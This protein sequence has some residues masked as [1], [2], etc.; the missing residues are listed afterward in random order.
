MSYRCQLRTCNFFSLVLA[1]SGSWFDYHRYCRIGVAFKPNEE[2][3]HSVDIIF[4]VLILNLTQ[5]DM[6]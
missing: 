4:S 5:F 2:H 3:L 1:D 6:T